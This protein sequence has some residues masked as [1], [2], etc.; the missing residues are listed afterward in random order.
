MHALQDRAGSYR[1]VSGRGGAAF[2]RRAIDRPGRRRDGF[3]T[4]EA[5][6]TLAN[7]DL[8]PVPVVLELVRPA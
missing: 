7:V 2:L 5:H 1:N 3:L 4:F 6:T 8:Q